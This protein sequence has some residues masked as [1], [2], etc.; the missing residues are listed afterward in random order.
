MQSLQTASTNKTRRNVVDPA[1]PPELI[2]EQIS[3]QRTSIS[4][5]DILEP[6]WKPETSPRNE[7]KNSGTDNSSG[8]SLSSMLKD[9]RSS[10][11]AQVTTE[12]TPLK[13]NQDE[14]NINVSKGY[15]SS[16]PFQPSM[17]GAENHDNKN[18]QS[19]QPLTNFNT[20]GNRF[21]ICRVPVRAFPTNVA[22]HNP[23]P[24]YFVLRSELPIVPQHNSTLRP[25]L[26]P[27]FRSANQNESFLH[28][29]NTVPAAINV[30]SGP[31][32]I[33]LALPQILPLQ[34]SIIKPSFTSLLQGYAAQLLPDNLW[35][36]RCGDKIPEKREF[37]QHDCMNLERRKCQ[38]EI[39][40]F[41]YKTISQFIEHC[42]I[43]H[44]KPEEKL[45]CP[46]CGDSF[47][48]PKGLISHTAL[49]GSCQIQRQCSN[50]E[51]ILTYEHFHT[52]SCPFSCLIASCDEKFK[53]L[54]DLK[55]HIRFIHIYL[56]Q[57][58]SLKS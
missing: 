17:G 55:E 21:P 9:V 5:H 22:T 29:Q 12:F 19:V 24:I 48:G 42:Y 56:D 14:L 28:N 45:V 33:G 49:R 15:G 25:S 53:T 50:C 20:C 39:C 58:V 1:L 7:V 46:E 3:R 4:I 36:N 51:E 23:P 44:N 16:K 13:S 8:L 37:Q 26:M 6:G 2:K 30:P 11:T 40:A 57:F 18:L 31:S 52:S 27:S 47:N 32:I 38:F 43:K 34:N 35:C 54:S 41:K 10:G